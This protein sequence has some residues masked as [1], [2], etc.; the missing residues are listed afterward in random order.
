[1]GVDNGLGPTKQ[2][3]PSMSSLLELYKSCAPLVNARY[4]IE[5]GLTADSNLGRPDCLSAALNSASWARV[6]TRILLRASRT[7]LNDCAA[8]RHGHAA[9]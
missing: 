5:I 1:M 3:A 4:V 7:G 8:A 6:S 2:S 9:T